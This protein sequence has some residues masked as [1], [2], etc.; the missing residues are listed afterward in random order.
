M[1]VMEYHHDSAV[2]ANA[3]AALPGEHLKAH[4]MPGHWLLARLGKRVLRPGGLELTRLML[5][6]LDIRADDAVV[7][8]APGLGVTAAM[9]LER[10]PARYTAIERDPAAAAQVNRVLT[11]PTQRCVTAS[12][13]ATG[14]D[15]ASATVLYGEAMLSMQPPAAKQAIIAEAARVLKPGGRY[16]MHELC[17]QPDD[18]AQETKDAILKRMSEAVHVGVRPLTASEWRATIEAQGLRVREIRTLPFHLLEPRRMIQDEGVFGM[19]RFVFRALRDGDARRRVL[20]M[21]RTFRTYRDHLAAVM[22]VA[23]KP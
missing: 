5:D 16:G 3:H 23:E 18:L 8:F 15:A 9:T 11:G 14:L 7:E 17:L 20:A 6:T 2:D 19:A 22:I 21:R 10:G 13:E 4:K 1:A 12:A